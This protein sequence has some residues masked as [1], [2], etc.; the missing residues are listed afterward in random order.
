MIRSRMWLAIALASMATPAL[1]YDDG[2]RSLRFGHTGGWSYDNRDDDRDFPNNGFFPG[3]FA[4][5]PG[6]AS[7][8]KAGIIGSTPWRSAQPYP[9]QVYITQPP[10]PTPCRHGDMRTA[11]NCR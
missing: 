1:A 8:G 2:F 10:Y 6:A 4:A 5:N 9:S 7:I 11:A 3:N